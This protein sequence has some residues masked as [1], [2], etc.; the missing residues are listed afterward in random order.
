M[1][2]MQSPVRYMVP[3]ILYSAREGVQVEVRWLRILV[4]LGLHLEQR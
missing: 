4:L 1:V 2:G 3:I